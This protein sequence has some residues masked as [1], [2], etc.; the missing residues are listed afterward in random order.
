MKIEKIQTGLRTQTRLQAGNPASDA[1]YI[2]R[3]YKTI[4]C[5]LEGWGSLDCAGDANEYSL[6]VCLSRSGEP[7]W[8]KDFPGC[9][10]SWQCESYRPPCRQKCYNEFRS[11]GGSFFFPEWT[12]C[13]QACPPNG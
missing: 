2:Q 7:D 12:R 10:S 5:T 11:G 13:V 8:W 1:C 6:K 3:N 9:T 4:Q